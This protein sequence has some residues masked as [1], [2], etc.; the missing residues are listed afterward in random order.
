MTDINWLKN[1]NAELFQQVTQLF[2]EQT[3]PYYDEAVT[4]KLNMMDLKG[5]YFNTIDAGA[6]G[7]PNW[8]APNHRLA[9]MLLEGKASRASTSYTSKIYEQALNQTPVGGK[10]HTILYFRDVDVEF[11]SLFSLGNLNKHRAMGAQV[12]VGSPTK[13]FLKA[14]TDF[15]SRFAGKNDIFQ[16]DKG[17]FSEGLA[18]MENHLSEA[19]SLS[20]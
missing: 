6:P 4:D 2:G 14:V 8:L 15:V 17:T 9:V 20:S 10:L 1:Y 7:A 18:T 13:G 12:I 11:Q 5:F 19:Y 16:L 3:S